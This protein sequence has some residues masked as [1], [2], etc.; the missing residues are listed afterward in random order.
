MFESLRT[1][2]LALLSSQFAEEQLPKVMGYL[3]RD[4]WVQHL[5]A[6]IRKVA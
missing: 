1:S 3:S 4:F 2:D 6:E 5:L